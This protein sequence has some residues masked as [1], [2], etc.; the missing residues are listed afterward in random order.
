MIELCNNPKCSKELKYTLLDSGVCRWNK[1]TFVNNQLA[2][3][4]YE[5]FLV[6]NYFTC[7]DKAKRFKGLHPSWIEKMKPYLTPWRATFLRN[8][9]T[10]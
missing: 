6:M 7:K 9:S 3:C 8:L 1:P 5:C 2:F 10:K 4:D